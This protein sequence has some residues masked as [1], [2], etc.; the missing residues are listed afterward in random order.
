MLRSGIAGSCGCFTALFLAFWTKIWHYYFLPISY[1]NKDKMVY[2]ILKSTFRDYIYS[3]ILPCK[4]CFKVLL[5]LV[6]LIK[7]CLKVYI[8]TYSETEPTL[9]KQVYP[10]QK[11]KKK[12]SSKRMCY[13]KV[14]FCPY[15]QPT[16]SSHS[17]L[18]SGKRTCTLIHIIL[19]GCLLTSQKLL[20]TTL[21]RYLV[22]NDL[23]Q[24]P[25]ESV[26]TPLYSPPA[27]D[28]LKLPRWH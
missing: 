13:L 12:R 11:I 2:R 5:Q 15:I 27:A 25:E 22:M 28:G 26:I 14:T 9:K 10:Y 4:W 6:N 24:L 21:C 1:Y 8:F 18:N 16:V 20:S 23:V 3:V 19:L 17:F 7:D